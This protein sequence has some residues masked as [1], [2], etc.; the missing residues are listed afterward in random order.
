MTLRTLARIT[1][2]LLAGILVMGCSTSVRVS[3]PPRTAT[4][5]FLMSQAAAKAI[6]QLSLEPLRGR[7]VFVDA[8][9]F[10]ASEQEFVI[11]ELRAHMFQSGVQVVAE[12]ADSDIVMEVRTGGIGID[13]TD[14]LL[15][16]PSLLLRAGTD[17]E[18]GITSIPL[19][20]P[21]LALAKNIDQRGIASVAYV[22]YWRETGEIVGASGPMLGFTA[23]EDWWFLGSGPNTVGDI[24]TVLPPEE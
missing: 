7:R 22:A 5:Q 18:D 21:E 1:P 13:R 3:D 2:L 11:G 6:A 15:G 17:S 24:P 20:T 12:R 14:F 8:Q 9:Y 19:A 10:V 23:R 4:E 16:I